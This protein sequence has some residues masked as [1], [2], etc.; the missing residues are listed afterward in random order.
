MPEP[1]VTVPGPD[2]TPDRGRPASR[3]GH[4][5]DLTAF[6]LALDAVG[7]RSPDDAEFLYDPG[8]A[9][10][11]MRRRNLLRYLALMAAVRPEVMLLA[12]APGHRGMSV[13]GIPFT[14]ARELAAR[15]GLI[16]GRPEGDGFELPE[17]PAAPWE[18]SSGIV[19]RALASWRGPLPLLWGVYPNHPFVPGDRSTNRPPRT[20]EVRAGAPVALAL[21]AA[22]RIRVIAAVGRKAQRAMAEAGVSAPALRHP[23][24]GGA[25][26][27]T[28]QLHELNE[29]ML[30]GT[31]EAH[32]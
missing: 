27:F 10:G 15:P 25:A 12:E 11:A 29:R 8:T 21:A 26:T 31:V 16:T 2:A 18:A 5:P 4:E 17:R 13:S 1:S 20:H 28:T 9:Q 23:A 3:R 7:R 32:G 30:A 14:S 19:W 6:L 24:Q 22:F